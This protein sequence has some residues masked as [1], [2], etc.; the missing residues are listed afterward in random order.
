MNI[1]VVGGGG[2]EHALVW[3]IKKSRKVKKIYCAPGNGGIA[4]DAECVAIE[5][6]D[7]KGMVQ[8]ASKKKIDLTV[9]GPE[10]PLTLGIVDAFKEKGLPV[11]GPSKQAAELEGSKQFAK[12]LMAK[13]RIPTAEY[14]VFKDAEK[15]TKYLQSI[16]P[17]I[18]LKADG[19]AAG[20]GVLL[21]QSR[22][23][24]YEGVDRIMLKKAFGESG[25]RLIVEE[26]LRGEEASV[27]AI[28]DGDDLVILPAAQDHKAVFEGDT[29]PNT[30]GMG[31]YAP[32]P[33]VTPKMHAI[34]KEKILLP[35]IRGMKAEGRPYKGVLYAGL[36]IDTGGP[37][38][39]E[40]NCRFGDPE[41]QA[42]LPLVKTDLVDLMLASV[43]G[44]LSECSAE[45]RENAAVCVVMASGGYPGNYE[46]GKVIQGLSEVSNHVTVFHAGTKRKGRHVVTSGG[47]VLG[48]T[49]VDKDI[50][51]AIERVYRGVG[52]IAFDGAYYR[53]DIGHRALKRSKK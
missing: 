11:F 45:I 49:A 38:V 50:K 28:T 47:R 43:N 14:R 4:G 16:E 18:V 32:A 5:A 46:K 7:I 3:K 34:V 9:V 24:A 39:L 35:T 17:P 6:S 15:A 31:A 12:D 26:F 30:G 44:T 20:K 25:S 40:F 29:G 8:F 22:T 51:K 52:K 36:M 41:I 2:R 42:I 13:Y 37:K 27:L 33:V 19:L 23:E 10:L 48:V 53:R 1:L 21:C